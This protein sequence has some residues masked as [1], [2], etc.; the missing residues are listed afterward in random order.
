MRTLRRLRRLWTR[1][2]WIMLFKKRVEKGRMFVVRNRRGKFGAATD[3]IFALLE[4]VE[5]ETPYLFTETQLE[6]ARQRAE[7][8]P[9][10]LLQRKRFFFF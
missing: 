10:D 3:Y 1:T 6:V 2:G 4:G 9:E 5:G 7:K 8:N